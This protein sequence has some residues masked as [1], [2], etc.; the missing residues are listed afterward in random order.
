MC[1]CVCVFAH[2]P[3]TTL[4]LHRLY[5]EL[6]YN[7]GLIIIIIIII[8]IFLIYKLLTPLVD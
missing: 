5:I 6:Y 2:G 3:I 7:K 8:N 4:Q 1:V